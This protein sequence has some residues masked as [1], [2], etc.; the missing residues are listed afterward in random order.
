MLK[1]DLRARCTEKIQKKRS[2][3]REACLLQGSCAF[4]HHCSFPFS[5]LAF[6][7]FGDMQSC[8]RVGLVS[9][10]REVGRQG[11]RGQHIDDAGS[12]SIHMEKSMCGLAC[13]CQEPTQRAS[14]ES[15][16]Q[17]P[18]QKPVLRADAESRHLDPMLTAGSVARPSAGPLTCRP[19]PAGARSRCLSHVWAPR[20]LAT[21]LLLLLL[22]IHRSLLLLLL[23]L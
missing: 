4:R 11:T 2:G 23:L 15:R 1:V 7:F 13:G 6:A 8:L 10:G 17:R 16:R 5:P 3:S 19:A 14:V 12:P 21:W 22:R 18:R 20:L 9:L